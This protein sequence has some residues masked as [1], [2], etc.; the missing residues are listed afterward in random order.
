MHVRFAVLAIVMASVYGCA[1]EPEQKQDGAAP[2]QSQSPRDYRTGSRLP[3]MEDDQRP[4][5]G[6]SKDDYMDERNRGGASGVRG[7]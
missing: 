7:N 2:A 5:S 4:V 6:M 1:T 3:T